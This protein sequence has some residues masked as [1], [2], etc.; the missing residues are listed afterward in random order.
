MDTIPAHR[1]IFWYMTFPNLTHKINSRSV[2]F[3]NQ[4]TKTNQFDFQLGRPNTSFWLNVMQIYWCLIS[5]HTEEWATEK[6]T[7]CSNLMKANGLKGKIFG[8]SQSP[9]SSAVNFIFYSTNVAQI[10]TSSKHT[11]RP[12]L[13]SVNTISFYWMNHWE[14]GRKQDNTS[15][16]TQ[17]AECRFGRT[18]LV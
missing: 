7:A 17:H 6:W 2:V 12:C 15:I 1:C 18:G 9:P 11:A 8:H 4:Y 13:Q 10:Q 14:I 5:V 3:P 16:V